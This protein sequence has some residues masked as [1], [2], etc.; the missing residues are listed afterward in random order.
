MIKAG[1]RVNNNIANTTR[2]RDLNIL[3]LR[4]VV[5]K[6]GAKEDRFNFQGTKEKG[7]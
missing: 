2:K 5:A 4:G 7:L 3:H 6:L 1:L